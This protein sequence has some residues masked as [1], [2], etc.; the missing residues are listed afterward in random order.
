MKKCRT[1]I[2]LNTPEDFCIFSSLDDP[3]PYENEDIIPR[4]YFVETTQFPF[5]NNNWY[6]APIVQ[7]G[8]ETKSKEYPFNQYSDEDL[9]T[10]ANY[11][12]SWQPK[13]V[14][15][16]LD[17][18]ISVLNY[19]KTTKNIKY[20]LL[21]V[22]DIG[23]DYNDLLVTLPTE[24]NLDNKSLY[25]FVVENELTLSD[26]F[27]DDFDYY[28]THPGIEGHQKIKDILFN[29]IKTCM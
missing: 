12:V 5:K 27:P 8:L 22:Q 10:L 19:L 4:F 7:L 9:V 26:E 16:D 1:N 18:T 11:V 20:S 13:R 2:L 6:S 3:K 25:D 24:K 17:N 15:F 21:C 29:Q 28:D 14:K 23:E